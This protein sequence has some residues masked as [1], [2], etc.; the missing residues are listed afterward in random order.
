MPGDQHEPQFWR[1]P[2]HQELQLGQDLRAEVMGVVDDQPQP[3]RQ[4]RQ[5]R[6]QP[7]HHRPAVQIRCCGQRPHQ[8]RPGRPTPQRV[9]DT[10][11][12]PPR[13]TLIAARRRP[14]DPPG[15]ARLGDPRPHQHRLPA[16]GRRRYLDQ[17]L[18]FGQPPEQRAAGH[19]C[20]PHGRHLSGP[21][22]SRI[23]RTYLPGHELTHPAEPSW[24]HQGRD[25][26]RPG[27]VPS[28][29]VRGGCLHYF[30]TIGHLTLPS[31]PALGIGHPGRCC[32]PPSCC[33]HKD[34]RFSAGGLTGPVRGEGR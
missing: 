28:T 22:P 14:R 12:E 19:D 32:G 26:V 7:F 25:V 3:V 16:P 27:Q 20:S 6:Q 15:Q 4:R 31:G 34:H 18:R 8:R 17:T 11:P 33:A 5:V 24:P 10:D 2:Q 1:G 29:A 23:A 21:E 13:I 9:G 30:S